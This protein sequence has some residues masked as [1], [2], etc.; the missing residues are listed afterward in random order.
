MI[1][2][3]YIRPVMTEHTANVVMVKQQC[4]TLMALRKNAFQMVYFKFKIVT[5]IKKMQKTQTHIYV[6]LARLIIY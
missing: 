6:K 2:G 5:L 3:S 4:L 1:R